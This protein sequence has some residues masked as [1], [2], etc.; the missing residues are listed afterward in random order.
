MGSD[1]L[2]WRGNI[3]PP[4]ASPQAAM[5]KPF[6][7]LSK[8]QVKARFLSSKHTETVKYYTQRHNLQRNTKLPIRLQFE[9]DVEL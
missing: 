3:D 7:L 4:G 9:S 1:L 5:V 2:Y 6:K 8:Y